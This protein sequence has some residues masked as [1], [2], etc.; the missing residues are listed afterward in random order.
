MK[1]L[2]PHSAM[3]NDDF[4]LF[5]IEKSLFYNQDKHRLPA[6]ANNSAVF[7]RPELI[8]VIPIIQVLSVEQ[9]RTLG[10]TLPRVHQRGCLAYP[11]Q[12]EPY[13]Q[14]TKRIKKHN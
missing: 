6:L 8:S 10:H 4:L 14:K 1:A 9:G 5:Y 7:N 2:A 11:L 13:Q 3:K 12:F